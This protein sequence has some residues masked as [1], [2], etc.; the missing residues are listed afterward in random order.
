MAE[1]HGEIEE[2]KGINKGEVVPKSKD[3]RKRK[4]RS[5]LYK[6]R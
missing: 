5:A 1:E 6:K 4:K 3:K 2:I